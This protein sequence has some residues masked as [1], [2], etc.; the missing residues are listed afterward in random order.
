MTFVYQMITHPLWL[1]MSN[2][3]ILLISCAFYSIIYDLTSC[4]EWKQ[5]CDL[6]ALDKE[7]QIHNLVDL[8]CKFLFEQK[9]LQNPCEVSEIPLLECPQIYGCIHMYNSAL[10]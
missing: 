3:H 6:V 1:H 2:W 7:L 4:S 9:N 5:A 8:M 10:S